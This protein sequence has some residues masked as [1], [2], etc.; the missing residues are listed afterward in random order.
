MINYS[1]SIIDTVKVVFAKGSYVY[2]EYLIKEFQNE[3]TLNFIN[4][5]LNQSSKTPVEAILVLLSAIRFLTKDIDAINNF[6]KT[7]GFEHYIKENY[8]ELFNISINKRVQGNILERGLPL[9]EVLGNKSSNKPIC[10]IELGAS[11][12]LIGHIL[13]NPDEFLINKKIYFHTDQKIPSKAKKI[14]YYLGIDID[15]PDK[16]WLIACFSLPEDAKLI[17]SYIESIKEGNNF[18][19]MKSSAIG[20]TK[21][22]EVLKLT[23]NDYEIIVLNSFMLYQFDQTLKKQ[24]IDEIL[25]F[26]N[27]NNRHW[28]SQEVELLD[29]SIDN[30]YFIEWD[31]NKIIKLPDDKCRTWKWLK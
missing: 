20:F 15:P 31:M 28:I 12:G 16:D 19:L 5:V 25:D 8:K 10:V 4:E 18:Q 30:K 2:S 29:S 11:Y 22:S 9:L 1:E 26:T 3:T 6:E 7:S 24:L 27:F 21:L 14:D 23:E 17:K 13:L